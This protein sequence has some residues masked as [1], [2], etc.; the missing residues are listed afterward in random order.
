M[1][2]IMWL[3]AFSAVIVLMTFAWKTAMAEELIWMGAFIACIALPAW[4]M[5]LSDDNAES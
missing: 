1:N 2:K 4:A 5:V 3:G